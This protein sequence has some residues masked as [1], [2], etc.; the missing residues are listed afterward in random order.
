MGITDRKAREKA[1]MRQRIVD[2]AATL[3]LQHGYAGASIR[4]IAGQIEYSPTTIYLYFADKDAIFHA[5]HQ[6]GFRLFFESFQQV[7]KQGLAPY[8]KLVKLGEAYM[9]FAIEQPAYYEL[10][11]I[12]K[13]P[14]N[15]IQAGEGWDDGLRSKEILHHIVREC[16]EAGYIGGDDLEA[17][18]FMIWSCVHGMASL[19]VRDRMHMYEDNEALLQRGVDAMNALVKRTHSTNA[20]ADNPP[21]TTS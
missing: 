21:T 2:A 20:S 3:F 16:M 13:G 11:F 17:N 15:A 19:Y 8:D 4:A 12:E 5:V 18:A 14:M 9:R 1:E 10:M 7:L 6:R